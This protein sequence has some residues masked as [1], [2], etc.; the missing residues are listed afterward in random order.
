MG[1]GGSGDIVRQVEVIHSVTETVVEGRDERDSSTQPS[2]TGDMV[3]GVQV[4][5]MAKEFA[6]AFTGLECDMAIV[7]QIKV[8]W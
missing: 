3:S 8:I 1:E 6:E 5:A 2:V 4:E 7:D